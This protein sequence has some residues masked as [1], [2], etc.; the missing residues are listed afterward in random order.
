MA[1]GLQNHYTCTSLALRLVDIGPSLHGT[2][3]RFLSLS[4]KNFTTVYMYILMWIPV[5][6]ASHTSAPYMYCTCTYCQ[7]LVDLFSLYSIKNQSWCS[8]EQEAL[9]VHV[10]QLTICAI[11]LVWCTLY[12]ALVKKSTVISGFTPSI[13]IPNQTTDTAL[14]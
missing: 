6:F 9:L 1:D 12:F 11:C 7:D 13:H 8:Q 5:P 10:W 14:R 3:Y 2:Q 4:S